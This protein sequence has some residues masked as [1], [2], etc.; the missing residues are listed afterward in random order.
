[1]TQKAFKDSHFASLQTAVKAMSRKHL[2]FEPCT[3]S[4]EDTLNLFV[5]GKDHNAVHAAAEL[6]GA[7]NLPYYIAL[8]LQPLDALKKAVTYTVS[9]HGRRSFGFPLNA[10]VA[11]SAPDYLVTQLME[12]CAR[13]AEISLQYGLVMK[14]LHALNDVCTTPGQ[15]NFLWPSVSVIANQVDDLKKLPLNVKSKTLP[16]VSPGLR[17]A[18]RETAATIALFQMLGDAPTGPRTDVQIE[19]NNNWDCQA[20]GPLG[21]YCGI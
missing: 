12:L 17:A 2:Q 3:F 1:M 4:H 18:C 10:K 5:E 16:S 19:L 7:G 11:S 13:R 14:T 20:D 6:Y 8:P 9:M 15:V 21:V